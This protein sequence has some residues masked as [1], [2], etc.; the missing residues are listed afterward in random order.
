MQGYLLYCPVPAQYR[1]VD[2]IM[3]G[4]VDTVSM[5]DPLQYWHFDGFVPNS[6]RE[7]WHFGQVSTTFTII[8]LFT[9]RAAC[10][11][12]KF[13]VTSCAAPNPNCVSA[14]SKSPNSFPALKLRLPNILLEWERKCISLKGC[15]SFEKWANSLNPNEMFEVQLT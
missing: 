1:H 12:V 13:M 9:P 8:S 7:P 3:N 11:N 10:A 15:D 5:P 2:L 14:K 6:H 4:P